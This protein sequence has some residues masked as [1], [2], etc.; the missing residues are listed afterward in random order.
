MRSFTVS[1]DAPALVKIAQGYAM[2]RRDFS[3]GYDDHITDDCY[4]NDEGYGSRKFDH[5]DEASFG[6]EKGSWPTWPTLGPS[7][8][9]RPSLE[10]KRSR[11]CEQ[12]HRQWSCP[13]N[14]N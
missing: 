3:Q 6:G 5:G 10:R 12:P 11:G 1:L 2:C 9:R 7:L 8:V 4:G 13:A 14:N